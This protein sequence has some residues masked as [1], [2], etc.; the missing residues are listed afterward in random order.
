MTKRLAMLVSAAMALA[1]ACQHD[2]GI[3]FRGNAVQAAEAARDRETLVMMEFYTDWCSWC[4]RLEKD[5]FTHPGVAEEL[6]KLVAIRVNAERGG[7]DLANR[8]GVDSYPTVVFVDADGEEVDRILGYLPPE[9]FLRQTRRIRTGDTFMA[10]L[11]R[12][13]DD[14]ADYDALSRAVTGLLERSDPEGAIARI[15]AFHGSGDTHIHDGCVGLMFQA[16][17][18]LQTR[19]YE[20][21]AK[22]Y[23][24]GW[25]AGFVVPDTDGTRRLHAL[26]AEGIGDLP[27]PAQSELLREAR[28][29]DA[30]ELLGAV[31]MDEVDPVDLVGVADFAFENGHYDLAA[32]M[33]GR[34]FEEVGDRLDPDALNTGAWHLYLS[35][36]SLDVGL[37]MA[38]RAYQLNP[39]TDIADT[40]A[41]LLYAT[42]DTEAALDL[43][44]IAAAGADEIDAAFYNEG[45]KRMEAGQD[46]GDRPAFDAYPG[47]PIESLAARSR[48]II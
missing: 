35:S 48:R 39:S 7:E 10:C 43:E 17:T 15:K 13:A 44:R 28:F 4:R 36:R 30:S 22:L 24:T 14:P 21:A 31:D 12:L 1:V 42:G 26:V 40:L 47:E 45:L 16:R 9:E 18:V 27:Q 41:R 37:A 6:R 23:R 29:G 32:A 25:S 19:L 8:F 20:R 33:Y 34:W 38:R 46:L 3:W 5:T 2:G 11:Y